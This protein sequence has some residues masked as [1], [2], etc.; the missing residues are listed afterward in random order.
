VPDPKRKQ[1]QQRQHR[2]KLRAQR[3]KEADAAAI[4]AK[5]PTPSPPKVSKRAPRNKTQ[6]RN[7]R[8][9]S[10]PPPLVSQPEPSPSVTKKRKK[11]TTTTA[12]N[13]REAVEYYDSRRGGDNHM[14][15]SAV[16]RQ[17]GIE[18]RTF[19]FYVCDN[20]A[21]R[22]TIG[23]KPGKKSIVNSED[24]DFIVQHAARADRA[25]EG[26]RCKDIIQNLHSLRANTDNE[27][28]LKQCAGWVYKT[29]PQ[30]N[31]DLLK[32]GLKR[33]QKTTSKRSACNVAQQFRWLTMLHA[34]FDY[35]CTHNTGRCNLTGKS[36]G[37]LI[38]HFVVGGDEACL[39][40]DD[41]RIV[42]AVGTR[43]H[44]KKVSDTRG[45]ITMF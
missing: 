20:V 44:E 45:S 12:D 22:K 38:E 24:A 41:L 5:P 7:A 23:S 27:L 29:M 9:R 39:M 8:G 16:A 21:D 11:Y 17:F 10:A 37:E 13:L 43:K 32:Q 25:N 3:I 35:L 1:Q 26:L 6:R 19:S 31:P 36:F 15:K 18:P 34:G 28:T 2:N 14:S 30:N 33:T 42:G 4:A 40:A